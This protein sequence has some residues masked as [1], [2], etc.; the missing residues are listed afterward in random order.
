MRYDKPPLTLEQQIAQLKQRGMLFAD[1]REAARILA[2][3]NYYRL[4]AYWYPF[5]ADPETHDFQPE[6]RFEDVIAHYEF[7]RRLRLRVMDAI[8]RFEIALRTQFAYHLAH[9]YNGWAYEDSSLFA[10]LTQHTSRLGTLDRELDRSTET[11][12]RH[13]KR[14]YSAPQRPPC[15]LYS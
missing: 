12:I 10:D 5:Y 3:L 1:E 2:R 4:T 13:Y 9:R 15:H 7:D 11:F 6:T 8:E 14:K